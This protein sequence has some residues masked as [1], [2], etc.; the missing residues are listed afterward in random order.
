MLETPN[1]AANMLTGPQ[2]GWCHMRGQKHD[3]GRE[4]DSSPVVRYSTGIRGSERGRM[5][6]RED[7]ADPQTRAR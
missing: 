3:C 7:V 6:V 1:A 4:V 2:I 5:Q